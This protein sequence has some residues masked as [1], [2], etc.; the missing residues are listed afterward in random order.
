[1]TGERE[2]GRESAFE[3]RREGRDASEFDPHLSIQNANRLH[4]LLLHH[5]VLDDLGVVLDGSSEEDV[6]IR[7]TVTEEEVVDGLSI[8]VRL[9]TKRRGLVSSR[10]EFDSKEKP[11]T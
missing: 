3:E 10:E 11:L 6:E 2:E 5:P 9:S 7:S 1:M 8:E 4:P